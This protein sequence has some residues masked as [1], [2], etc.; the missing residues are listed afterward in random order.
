MP[1]IIII[2]G[3]TSSGLTIGNNSSA[4]VQNTGSALDFTV[5]MNG[6]M[7]VIDGGYASKTAVKTSGSMFVSG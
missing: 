5:A 7:S 6:A 1:D 3:V 2:D 4:R